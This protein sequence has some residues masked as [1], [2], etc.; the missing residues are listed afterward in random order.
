MELLM[1]NQNMRGVSKALK[2]NFV[3]QSKLCW[4]IPN[5]FVVG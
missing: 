4:R 5:K 3:G 1:L 2:G